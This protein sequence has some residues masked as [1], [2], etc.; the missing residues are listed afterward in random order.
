MLINCSARCW[1]RSA[2]S[3]SG[4]SCRCIALKWGKRQ[5]TG[6]EKV[7]WFYEAGLRLHGER[8]FVD[9]GGGNIQ[10]GLSP[11][12]WETGV[13]VREAIKAAFVGKQSLFLK[14]FHSIF[15]LAGFPCKFAEEL[16]NAQ[17]ARLSLSIFM[18]ISWTSA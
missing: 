5:F 13:T 8:K 17:C 3:K 4:S 11:P 16:D 6:I 10:I 7:G 2:C 15:N 1:R 14:L 12:A 18:E 9:L